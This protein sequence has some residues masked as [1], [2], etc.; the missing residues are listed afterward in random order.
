MGQGARL[1]NWTPDRWRMNAARFTGNRR[2]L[3]PPLP[4][5]WV[6][7]KPAPAETPG[8]VKLGAGGIIRFGSEVSSSYRDGWELAETNIR[9]IVE[10][11]GSAEAAFE[12][13]KQQCLTGRRMA[14]ERAEA[15]RWEE[16]NYWSGYAA[17]TQRWLEANL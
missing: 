11:T 3:L 14:E 2:W 1:L 7:V 4:E 16:A 15:H 13:V 12:Q 10:E 9:E 8:R 17:N 6:E 5:G